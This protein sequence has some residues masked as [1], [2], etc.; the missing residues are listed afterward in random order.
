MISPRQFN[1]L[2]AVPTELSNWVNC[3]MF[4][5]LVF[6]CIELTDRSLIPVSE[7]SY[8]LRIVMLNR[9]HLSTNL[10]VQHLLMLF[11]LQSPPPFLHLYNQIQKLLPRQLSLILS[12]L[13][14]NMEVCHHWLK[15]QSIQKTFW[16]IPFHLQVPRFRELLKYPRQRKDDQV[17]RSQRFKH[18][19]Q[20][21]LQGLFK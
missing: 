5:P 18:K 8:N 19:E 12:A 7:K 4:G 9:R 16:R 15:F 13:T 10:S 2:E 3:R 11:N 14:F 21:N 6:G 20:L 1:C 17:W